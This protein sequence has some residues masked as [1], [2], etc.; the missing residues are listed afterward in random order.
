M[1]R[2]AVI[3]HYIHGGTME[4]KARAQHCDRT[5][6]YH[7]L[8]RAH[9]ELQVLFDNFVQ[10]FAAIMDDIRCGNIAPEKIVL[11]TPQKVDKNFY[12]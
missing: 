9:R 8:D 1:L 2:R 7:R 10:R 5:T 12:S 3:E 11:Q 6:L 4:Q